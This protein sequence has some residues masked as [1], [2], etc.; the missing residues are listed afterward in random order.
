ME[1]NGLYPQGERSGS[2][3]AFEV[4][5]VVSEIP[6]G[7]VA[8][9]GLIARLIGREKNSRLVGRILRY[10]ELWGDYPCHRV[11][12]ASGRLAPGFAAQGELLRAEGV[13]LKPNGCVDLKKYGWD[14]E[15]GGRGQDE[16]GYAAP[17]GP[18]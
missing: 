6:R 18:V 12:N 2:D 13:A 5:A 9:Y 3:L 16:P 15:S 4:L 1:F 17:G 14:G 8:T 11:V 10:A 7:S